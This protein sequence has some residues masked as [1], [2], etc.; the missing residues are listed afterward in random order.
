MSAEKLTLGGLYPPRW[1]LTRMLPV[2]AHPRTA[3]A[4]VDDHQAGHEIR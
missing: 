1:D 2:L 4:D 3:G